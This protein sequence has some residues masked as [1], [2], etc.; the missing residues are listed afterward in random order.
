MRIYMQKPTIEDDQLPR[1]YQ[2]HLV[3][4]LLGG[5]NLVRESGY[6]GRGGQLTR[7][8]FECL[9]DA[10]GI[11]ESRRDRQIQQGYRI[12]FAEGALPDCPPD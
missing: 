4:D 9:E 11:L 1:F 3:R 6:V 5:W 2:L 7:E 10:V 12:T 8:H